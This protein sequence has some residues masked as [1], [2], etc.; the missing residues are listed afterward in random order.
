MCPKKLTLNA[1]ATVS[2]AR[3]VNFRHRAEAEQIKSGF[4]ERNGTHE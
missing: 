2:G 4:L 1:E 3:D